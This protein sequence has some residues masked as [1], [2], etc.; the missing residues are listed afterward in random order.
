MKGSNLLAFLGGA[1]VG[2]AI[3]LLYAPQSGK[4]TREQIKDFVED[5]V[6]DV[7][8]FAERTA[9]QVKKTVNHGISEAREAID[10]VTDYVCR[11]EKKMARKVDEKLA[12]VEK[13]T[14]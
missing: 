8:D 9:K 3:A 6:E 7:K 2:G 1:I 11:E 14:R 12:D 10:D 5:G 13:A 4:K